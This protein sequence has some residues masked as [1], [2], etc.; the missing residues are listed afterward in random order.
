[1]EWAWM[2]HLALL[3]W[4]WSKVHQYRFSDF[5]LNCL[6]DNETKCI[7]GQAKSRNENWMF[8]RERCPDF[9][10]MTEAFP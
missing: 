9:R 8:I 3:E 4:N 5:R 10:D 6:K 2:A 7:L 1:M